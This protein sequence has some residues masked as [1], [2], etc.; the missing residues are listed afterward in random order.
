MT[1]M[2]VVIVGH[3]FEGEGG[4]M[5]ASGLPAYSVCQRTLHMGILFLFFRRSL[6]FL[7]KLPVF[8]IIRPILQSLADLSA[9]V[10]LV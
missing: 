9:M 4:V 1:V 10:A 8:I 6:I 3:E 2:I 7:H 5:M